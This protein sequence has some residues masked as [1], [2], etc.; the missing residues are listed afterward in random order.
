MTYPDRCAP[1]V[2]LLIGCAALGLLLAS[3]PAEGGTALDQLSGAANLGTGC[4]G[5]FRSPSAPVPAICIARSLTIPKVQTPRAG[6]DRCRSRQP[7]CE[8]PVRPGV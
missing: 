4:V 3:R 7:L 5:A 1:S 8:A 6:G 2:V